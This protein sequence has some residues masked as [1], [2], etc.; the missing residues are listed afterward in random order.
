MKC[1]IQY[2]ASIKCTIYSFFLFCL[3][4]KLQ[5][6]CCTFVHCTSLYCPSQIL[7]F[8]QSEGLWQPCVEQVY[9]HDFSNSICSLVSLFGKFGNSCNISNFSIIICSSNLW[10]VIFDVAMT[11]S[12]RLRW[13]LAF[14][15]NKVFFVELRTLFFLRYYAV[16]HL[17]D[18]SIV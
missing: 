1:K 5:K 18:Y 2:F 4:I 14:L 7:R 3:F 15:S 16:R 6:Y 10:S 11:T 8:L 12:W 13:W 9:R 17:I